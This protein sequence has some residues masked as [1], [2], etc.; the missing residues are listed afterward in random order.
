[1]ILLNQITPCPP[2]VLAHAESSWKLIGKV[3]AR[4]DSLRK[5]LRRHRVALKRGSFARIRGTFGGYR[6][7]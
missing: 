1:M 2:V 6:P 5:S 7:A 3:A 4:Q